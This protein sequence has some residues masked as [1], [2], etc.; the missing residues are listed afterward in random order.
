M[1][2]KYAPEV[3][4]AVGVR[5]LELIRDLVLTEDMLQN[6]IGTFQTERLEKTR[7][8]MQQYFDLKGDVPLADVYTTQAVPR[9]PVRP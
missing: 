2:R 4:K 7:D 8:V 1:V 9:T 3:D 6:G 5:Q